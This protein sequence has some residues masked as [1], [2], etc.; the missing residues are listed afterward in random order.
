MIESVHKT[1]PAF[2][3]TA[4]LHVCS[5]RVSL[6]KL[7]MYLSIYETSSPSYILMAGIDACMEFLEEKGTMYFQKLEENLNVFYEK[8][9]SLKHLKVVRK[10]DFSNQEAF[11]F[12]E[13]KI[14]ILS[15]HP[16]VSGADL[17]RVLLE[18]YK[19]QMEM[20]C[21]NY[22]LALSSIMD[23]K[24][25]FDRLADALLEIDHALSMEFP[26][27]EA[28]QMFCKD[29]VYKMQIKQL[30]IFEAQEMENEL[31][32]LG[33]AIGKTSGSYVYLYPPGI[34]IIVPGEK[35]TK[36]FIEDIYLC[37]KKGLEVEGLLEEKISIV[38]Y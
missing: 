29:Y 1:L 21:G 8:T 4:L 5:E 34:P 7:K 28:N 32:S 30:E 17:Q 11:D 2:T 18:K 38:S 14:L 33:E 31:I 6:D 25:G 20:A 9:S 3:Q 24:E 16:S 10:S 22:T 19:L 26:L 15:K 35:I 37:K 27:Y 13:S 12:D 36:Q 23:T